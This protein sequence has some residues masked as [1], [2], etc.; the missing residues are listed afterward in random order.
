[1]IIF[2]GS[3]KCGILKCII[4]DT[5]ASSNCIKLNCTYTYKKG[6]CGKRFLRNPTRTT[7]GKDLQNKSVHVYRA[8]KAHMLMGEG[9]PEPPHLYNSAVLRKTKTE[10]AKANYVDSDALKA[11]VILKSSSLNN[12]IHNIG[13]HPIFVHYWSSHQLNVY[14]KY[15][16]ENDACIFVDATGSIIKKTM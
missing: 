1:M 10:I 15:A 16:L 6:N 9:D 3:C 4:E 8:E 13:L 2:S 5:D 11:L 14:K 12:V 7:V